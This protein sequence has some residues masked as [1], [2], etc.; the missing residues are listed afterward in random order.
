MKPNVGSGK[1][2]CLRAAALPE[3]TCL[4]QIT[5]KGDFLPLYGLQREPKE[6]DFSYC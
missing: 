1:I 3:D 6:V 5:S 4:L 2:L